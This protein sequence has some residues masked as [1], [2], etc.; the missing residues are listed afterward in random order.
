MAV[1][2]KF[3]LSGR[4]SQNLDRRKNEK[5]PRRTRDSGPKRARGKAQSPKTTRVRQGKQVQSTG[6]TRRRAAE[7]EKQPRSFAWLNRILVLLAAGVV[8]VAVLQAWITLQQIPVERISVTGEMTHTRAT[9]VQDMVQPALAGGFLGADLQQV[10]EQLSR[11]PRALPRLKILRK[12]AT[13]YDYRF[14][15]FE[16]HDYDPYP[17]IAAPV[18]V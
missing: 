15:D 12:P 18:A 6:A 14:E 4:G 3:T 10:R 17:N 8:M 16:L 1:A 7:T 9:A 13:I 11:E 2:V 5:G